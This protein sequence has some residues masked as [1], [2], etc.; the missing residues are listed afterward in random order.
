MGPHGHLPKWRRL[1]ALHES[2]GDHRIALGDGA[3]GRFVN[4]SLSNAGAMYIGFVRK[5]HQIV[6]H[7]AIVTINVVLPSPVGPCWIFKPFKNR[8]FV[9]IYFGRIPWPNPYKTI[10]LQD[11]ETFDWLKSTNIVSWHANR[12]A[13]AFH[14]EAVIA[15]D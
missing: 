11:R 8:Y 5:V 10:P 2:T 13:I 9:V 12:M 15:T 7:Q 1:D 4:F 14:G 3:T 6:N